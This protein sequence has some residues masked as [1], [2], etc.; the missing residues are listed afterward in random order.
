MS[1]PDRCHPRHC[2]SMDADGSQ[3]HAA[4]RGRRREPGHDKWNANV[5][6]ADGLGHCLVHASALKEGGSDW[7]PASSAFTRAT[8][9]CRTASRASPKDTDAS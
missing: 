5:P 4:A 6:E 2:C 9:A 8:A 7:K 3:T 1:S